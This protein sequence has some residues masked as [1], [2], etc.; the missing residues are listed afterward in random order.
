M[1]TNVLE[2]FIFLEKKSATSESLLFHQKI[3]SKKVLYFTFKGKN[4][5]N[6]LKAYTFEEKQIRK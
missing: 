6:P 3:F 2:N 1:F 5:K 4:V